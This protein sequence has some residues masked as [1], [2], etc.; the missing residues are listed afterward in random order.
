MKR[1]VV[2]TCAVIFALIVSAFTF[3]SHYVVGDKVEDFKLKNINGKMVSLADYKDAKGFI[4]IFSC[5]HCP[6]VKAYEDR[7]IALNNKYASKGY[8]V[9]AISSNDAVAYPADSYEN[10]VKHA[11]EKKYTFPYLYDETQEVAKKYGALKT[12]HVYILKKEK[13][14]LKIAYIGA[15]DDNSESAD[16]VKVKYAENAL[17][18]LLA[19]KEVSVKETKAIGCGLKYKK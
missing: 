8:P 4:I 1:P 10:M 2:I 3:Q 17:E 5:N 19:N 13:G 12:P 7:M 15:I 6:Y 9:I 16:Q 14:D 11:E 18:E